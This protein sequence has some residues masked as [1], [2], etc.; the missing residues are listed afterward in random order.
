MADL[1][2]AASVIQ[3]QGEAILAMQHTLQAV[4]EQ[5]ANVT[6]QPTQTPHV[7]KEWVPKKPET[8]NGS[9]RDIAAANWLYTVRHYVEAVHMPNERRMDFTRGLLTGNALTWLR[10]LELQNG[11][12]LPFEIFEERFLEFFTSPLMS[13]N[14]RRELRTMRQRGSVSNYAHVFNRKLLEA[15]TVPAHL[16]LEY[17]VDSLR[18]ELQAWVRP[19]NPTT[20]DEA[21][22]LAERIEITLQL[23]RNGGAPLV[24]PR[25][26][27]RNGPTP[28]Q[29]GVMNGGRGGGRF[30]GRNGGRFGHGRGGR[31]NGRGGGR[32][33][34]MQNTGACHICG[35][36]GHWKRECPNKQEQAN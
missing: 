19:H 10:A 12:L 26:N 11:E 30:G 15:R 28:M 25:Y 16:A 27:P 31:F 20:L 14:A 34:P 17:F 6:Q 18:P 1:E 33:R 22:S 2:A 29:L 13:E 8:Y 3:Q 32:G 5:L 9:K 36:E 21:Q 4:Q 24:M 35:Q 23:S 7:A